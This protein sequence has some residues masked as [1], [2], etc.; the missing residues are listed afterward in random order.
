MTLIKETVLIKKINETVKASIKMDSII[1][2]Q[3]SENKAM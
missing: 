1:G 2:K 3:N